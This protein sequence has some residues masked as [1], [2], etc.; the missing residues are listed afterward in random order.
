MKPVSDEKQQ[1]Q[2]AQDMGIQNNKPYYDVEGQNY[3]K[4]HGIICSLFMKTCLSLFLMGVLALLAYVGYIF[5][6]DHVDSKRGVPRKIYKDYS[7]IAGVDGL[8]FEL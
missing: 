8:L 7:D 1:T 5:Y 3:R 2:L 4:Q 6:L